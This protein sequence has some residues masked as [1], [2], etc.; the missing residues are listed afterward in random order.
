MYHVDHQS[1]R[2]FDNRQF[3]LHK[4]D[5]AWSI[6]PNADA[7]NETFL[8]GTALSGEAKLDEG[9]EISLKGKAGFIRISFL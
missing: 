9:S 5:D 2:F 1:A 3:S 7:K 6:I 4:G 8:N